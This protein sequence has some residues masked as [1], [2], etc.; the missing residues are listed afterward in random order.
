MEG[1]LSCLAHDPLHLQQGL[2]HRGNLVSAACLPAGRHLRLD[3]EAEGTLRPTPEALRAGPAVPLTAAPRTGPHH[4]WSTASAS[5]IRG[6]H[7]ILALDG[8]LAPRLTF[9]L[10][11]DFP[12][13]L[14]CLVMS[15]DH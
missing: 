11:Q 14:T 3:L 1:A 8:L 7:G 13:I 4:A 10:K 12:R 5:E 2:E 6:R 15:G 9:H